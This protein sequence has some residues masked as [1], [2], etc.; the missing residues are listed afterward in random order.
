MSKARTTRSKQPVKEKEVKKISVK[1]LM[2][3][4]RL[5][6]NKNNDLGID[7]AGNSPKEKSQ[8]P[9]GSIHDIL[10]KM[11]VSPDSPGNNIILLI[12]LVRSFGTSVYFTSVFY[13][14]RKLLITTD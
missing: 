9:I 7:I 4:Q 12:S 6:S 2:P 8:P 13:N 14:C 5:N 11:T 10:E 3:L 1:P